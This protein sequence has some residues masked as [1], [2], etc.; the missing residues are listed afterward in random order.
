MDFNNQHLRCEPTA[1]LTDQQNLLQQELLRFLTSW[2]VLKKKTFTKNEW[3][4]RG[5]GG[6]LLVL[7]SIYAWSGAVLKKVLQKKKLKK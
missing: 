6:L 2:A 1:L 5:E 4:Y 3:K 7:K